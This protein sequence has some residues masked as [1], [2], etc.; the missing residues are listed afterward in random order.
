MVTHLGS[1]SGG[2]GGSSSGSNITALA[3]TDSGDHQNFTLSKAV[4]LLI[5][6]RNGDFVDPSDYTFFGSGFKLTR[7]LA[8]GDNLNA[9][10]A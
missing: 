6:F 9:L 2:S 4:T 5:L 10:G 1:T 8:A 3:V 7:V